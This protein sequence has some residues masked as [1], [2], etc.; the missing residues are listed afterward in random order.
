MAR[1]TALT[2][3]RLAAKSCFGTGV[4]GTQQCA[5]QLTMAAGVDQRTF[6]ILYCSQYILGDYKGLAIPKC[7]RLW[8][9]VFGAINGLG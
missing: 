2:P 3:C 8:P 4:T 7:L 5:D 9:Y 6:T 1:T